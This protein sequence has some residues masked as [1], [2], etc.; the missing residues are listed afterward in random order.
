[1]A[2]LSTESMR[3]PYRRFSAARSRLRP[4][5]WLHADLPI[6]CAVAVAG[7]PLWDNALH[8][9][10]GQRPRRAAEVCELLQAYPRMPATVI[11]ERIGWDRGL[12]VL[13]AVGQANPAQH[14]V[15]GVWARFRGPWR[16][17]LDGGRVDLF[18][19]PGRW[20]GMDSSAASRTPV[21]A[22]CC[23]GG[24]GAGG[25]VTASWRWG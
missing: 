10:V 11:A 23:G 20:S 21:V 22:A 2:A 13:F 17:V 1:M 24:G 4:H 14:Q 5:G 8:V 9:R 7:A 16:A 15:S 18:P 12:T 6:L 25:R 3:T 19:A